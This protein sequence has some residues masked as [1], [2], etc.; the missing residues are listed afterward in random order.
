MQKRN[1]ARYLS[2]IIALLPFWLLLSCTPNP[3][4][5]VRGEEIN[6]QMHYIGTDYEDNDEFA[7]A[8]CISLAHFPTLIGPDHQTGEFNRWMWG[9]AQESVAITLDCLVNPDD[10]EIYEED[11]ITLWK[12]Q[13]RTIVELSMDTRGIYSGLQ[14]N[15]IYP[16]GA[17]TASSGDSKTFCYDVV[18]GRFL[19]GADV[20]A[21][22][23]EHALSTG[24]E[25]KINDLYG[26][27][28]F[29]AWLWMLS[30]E[31]LIFVGTNYLR[32]FPDHVTIPWDEVS[33]YINWKGVMGEIFPEHK[34]R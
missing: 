30:E 32:V 5:S 27:H 24:L 25:E 26:P 2:F 22:S 9:Q 17:A 29:D 4:L 23:Y 10:Y 8:T 19:D 1:P 16:P 21:I 20:F 15:V 33:E 6:Y 31:G 14:A 3:P 28:Y 34:I 7:K 18:S 13:R 11:G 12:L